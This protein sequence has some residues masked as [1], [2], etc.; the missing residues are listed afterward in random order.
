VAHSLAHF[1]RKT[2]HKYIKYS[3]SSSYWPTAS[4]SCSDSLFRLTVAV[5]SPLALR[6]ARPIPSRA[7]PCSPRSNGASFIVLALVVLALVVLTLVVLALIV[8]VVSSRVCCGA[9]IV[10]RACVRACVCSFSCVP[11]DV[12]VVVVV[13][14]VRKQDAKKV[15]R[16]C[17]T[18]FG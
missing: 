15:R 3:W 11:A 17:S 13:E 5:R 7:P 2:T 4:M 9:V 12:I 6:R 18:T 8:C 10:V 14:V 16:G 1:H